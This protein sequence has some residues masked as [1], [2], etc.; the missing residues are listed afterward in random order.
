MSFQ[1]LSIVSFLY[2]QAS[3]G[4][5]KL[6]IGFL[7]LLC[8][9][10]SISTSSILCS[11]YSSVPYIK[12]NILTR[13]DELYIHN[14]N[15]FVC[16]QCFVC[17]LSLFCDARNDYL[18]LTFYVVLYG[19]L[20]LGFGVTISLSFCRVLIIMEVCLQTWY[21]GSYAGG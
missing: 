10:L 17:L 9:L 7:S 14:W 11:Y 8:I 5:F 18:Y 21:V 1:I 19:S 12:K 20:T 16:V 3:P 15:I 13:L 6:Q 2:F 4:H